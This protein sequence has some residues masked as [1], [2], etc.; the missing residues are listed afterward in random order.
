VGSAL[1][2]RALRAAREQGHGVVLLVGDAAYYSRFGFS[3]E[4]TPPLWLPGPHEPHRL[5]AVELVT[6]ALD[7]AHGLIHATGRLVPK[8]DLSVLV[9]RL[10]TD[11]GRAL[12]FTRDKAASSPQAA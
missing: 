2:R 1:V 11:R 6:G 8:P 12:H 7:G 4:K 5:L 3:S 9:A 10:L